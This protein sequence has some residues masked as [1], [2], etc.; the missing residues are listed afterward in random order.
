LLSRAA[1]A[2]FDSFLVGSFLKSGYFDRGY[3]FSDRARHKAAADNAGT[4]RAPAGD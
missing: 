3:G 1:Y 4:G 2:W